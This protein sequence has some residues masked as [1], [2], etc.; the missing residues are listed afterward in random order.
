MDTMSLKWA[1]RAWVGMALSA[2]A[3]LGEE[4]SIRVEG[5]FQYGLIDGYLQTPAGGK[6]G[7]TS[8]SRPTLDEL[9]FD[10]VSIYEGSA[11]VQWARHTVYG[12]AESIRMSGDEVLVRPLVSQ[13]V[14]F[15]A[16]DRVDAYVQLDWYRLGYLRPFKGWSGHRNDLSLSLGG[17]V[18]LFDF[19]YTLDGT[20]GSVDRSY[21][22]VAVRL[23]GELGWTLTPRLSVCARAFESLPFSNTPS[24][25]TLGLRGYCRLVESQR[26]RAD[27]YVGV[28]WSRIDYE[29]NQT[30]PNHIHA[31]MGP[32]LEAGMRLC[33]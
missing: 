18:A 29:D 12:G 20:A 9:G 16:G 32:L 3:I 24:I 5:A 6:P 13:N 10:R 22:K 33:F 4:P 25:L 26:L 11:R 8:P 17:D 14:M 15:D 31:E 27:A 19:H 21:A 30:V 23:G 7:T 2:A 1:A 28:G